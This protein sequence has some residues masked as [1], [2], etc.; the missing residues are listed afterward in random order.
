MNDDSWR[1]LN[2]MCREIYLQFKLKDIYHEIHISGTRNVFFFFLQLKT[3]ER[4]NDL[5]QDVLNKVQKSKD[6][7]SLQDLPVPGLN[8]THDS[9]I[10][11]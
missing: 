11:Y 8:L 9:L 5:K 3:M 1:R 10:S 2:L 7:I 4:Y 6:E